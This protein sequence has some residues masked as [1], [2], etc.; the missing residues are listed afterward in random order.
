MLEAMRMTVIH[1]RLRLAVAG[2]ATVLLR[3]CCCRTHHTSL[4]VHPTAFEKLRSHASS[5]T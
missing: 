3:A 4:A 5:R 2:A 1:V